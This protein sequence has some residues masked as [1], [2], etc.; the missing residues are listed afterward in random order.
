MTAE[1]PKRLGDLHMARNLLEEALD[2]PTERHKGEK[3]REAYQAIEEWA[4]RNDVSLE[5]S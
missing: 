3:A 4:D 5:T 1:M 2:A